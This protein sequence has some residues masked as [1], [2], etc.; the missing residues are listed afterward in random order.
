MASESDDHSGRGVSRRA[1]AP[2]RR[3]APVP[4]RKRRLTLDALLHR[5]WFELLNFAESYK[6][7]TLA[8]IFFWMFIVWI[9]GTNLIWLFEQWVPPPADESPTYYG[10]EEYFNT[11]WWVIN[12]IMSAGVEDAATPRT[13]AGRTVAV[14]VVIIGICLV[15]VFTGNVV[16]ILWDRIARRDLM[17]VKPRIAHVAQYV[18]HVVVCNASAKFE[19]ILCQIVNKAGTDTKVVLVDPKADEYRTD[20]RPL[21]RSTFAVA[22]NPQSLRVLKQADVETAAALVVLTPD[23]AGL[24]LQGRDYQALLAALAVQPIVEVNPNL[25][26][27]LEVNLKSTTDFVEI[28]NVLDN[29]PLYI[30]AVC[31][32]DFHERLISQACLTPGLSHFFDLLLTVPS[33]RQRRSM[34]PRLFDT[35]FLREVH[36]EEAA[37]SPTDMGNDV[38]AVPLSEELAGRTF[39]DL[40]Q[41][42][43]EAD[44]VTLIGYLRWE[45]IGDGVGLLKPAVTLNPS[46]RPP[47]PGQPAPIDYRLRPDDELLVIARP[48]A[49]AA[50]R[51][52]RLLKAR[53]ARR[54]ATDRGKGRRG[55]GKTGAASH[56][57]SGRP[58]GD[59]DSS[60]QHRGHDPASDAQGTPSPD[61]PGSQAKE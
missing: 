37:A 35:I 31:A 23:D 34:I 8:I 53:A 6:L 19:P 12:A 7:Q 42:I 39:R 55:G 29:Y 28:F 3:P 41:V 10:P 18:D 40:R 11:Y 27:I 60:S 52:G 43:E 33:R 50:L 26:I 9:I 38:Y 30:E 49:Y 13:V 16:A 1:A 61:E 56:R 5:L 25:R 20:R 4:A 44:G 36:E 24:S 57:P 46:R 45:G 48:K 21:F 59:V 14:L 17:R 2:R 54:S 22:G 51:E 58:E 32:G 47:A 15:T